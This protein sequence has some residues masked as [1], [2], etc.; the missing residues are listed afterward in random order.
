LSALFLYLMLALSLGLGSTA[1]A[2]EGVTCL[3]AR[4]AASLGHSNGDGDQVPAD[5]GKAYPHHHAGCHGHHVL[6]P[7]TPDPVVAV[8]VLSTRL[9]PWNNSR[10]ALASSGPALRPPKA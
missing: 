2:T 7:T 8:T 6:A 3:D 1:H 10:I 9:L 5:A 4:T